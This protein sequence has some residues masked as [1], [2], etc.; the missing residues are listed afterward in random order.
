VEE[1]VAE[2]VY[3]GSIDWTDGNV[4][5]GEEVW[6]KSLSATSSIP[7]EAAVSTCVL[8]TGTEVI[9]VAEDDECSGGR[10]RW[11]NI[12]LQCPSRIY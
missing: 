4:G 12:I 6:I 10:G 2:G 8:H 9:V 11:C 3:D 7:G 5:G 1:G